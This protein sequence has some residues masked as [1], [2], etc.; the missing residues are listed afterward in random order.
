MSN[1]E[2]AVKV[3]KQWFF[4]HFSTSTS[5]Y[6]SLEKKNWGSKFRQEKSSNITWIFALKMLI[7]YFTNRNEIAD[8]ILSV[9]MQFL[10]HIHTGRLFCC[11]LTTLA[12]K[13]VVVSLFFFS[14]IFKICVNRMT[15]IW[16]VQSVAFKF[17][18]QEIIYKCC[19]AT[20]IIPYCLPQC[21]SSTSLIDIKFAQ[22]VYH[23]KCQNALEK[24]IQS[25]KKKWN[26]QVSSLWHISSDCFK[27]FKWCNWQLIIIAES[28]LK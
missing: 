6:L 8:T 5:H 11:K 14:A 27:D 28:S 13:P 24:S 1:K 2:Q 7:N 3:Y 12:R 17:L 9:Q 21:M 26:H 4:N 16:F 22:L 23:T 10:Y 20:R 15:T 19:L 25:V 18:E